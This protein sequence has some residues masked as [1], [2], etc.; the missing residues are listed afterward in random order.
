MKQQ[1]FVV[2]D[3]ERFRKLTR[4]E[5]FLSDMSQVVPWKNPC[6]QV[7][8][9]YHTAGNDRPPCAAGANAAYLFSSSLVQPLGS[10]CGGRPA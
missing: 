4:R 8:L 10:G 2:V 7:E 6:K 9:F 1:S 3:S 5:Q